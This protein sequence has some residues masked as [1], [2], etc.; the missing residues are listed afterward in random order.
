ML[1]VVFRKTDQ[2]SEEVRT[3]GHGLSPKLRQLLIMI[4]GKTAVGQLPLQLPQKELVHR[5][6][7]LEWDGFIERIGGVAAGSNAT[8]PSAPAPAAFTVERNAISAAQ[9]ARVRTI[10]YMS[11]QNQLAGALDDLLLQLEGVVDKKVLEAGITRWQQLMHQRGHDAI[12][13]TYL[14]QIRAALKD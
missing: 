11:N 12:M 13:Q 7:E 10:L 8:A 9:A 3:R 1:D 5:L 14:A 6:M 4:D 2:G